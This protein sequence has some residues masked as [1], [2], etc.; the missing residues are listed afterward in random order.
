MLSQAQTNSALQKLA[1]SFLRDLR[2]AGADSTQAGWGQFVGQKDGTQVGLYGTCAGS[3]TVALAYGC[4]RIPEGA[5]AYLTELWQQRNNPG[6]DGQRYF[7]L[8]ARLAFFLMALRQSDHPSFAQFVGDVDSELRDRIL[9]D[10]LFVGWQID[11]KHRGETGDEF[12]TAIGILAFGLT[13]RARH[14]VPPEIVR[15]AECLQTR[16]E[17]SP[18][19]NVGVR[20]LYLAAVTTVLEK[21]QV[22]G[23]LRRLVR[24]NRPR[25][26]NRDQ[27]SLYFWDYWFQGT[28][29]MISRRDYFHV[30]SD[31]LD[32]LLAC[33]S[34]AGQFQKLAALDVADEDLKAV[35]DSGLYFAGRQLAASNNQA[36]ISLAL[37]KIKLLTAVD[38]KINR[39]KFRYLHGIPTNVIGCVLFPAITLVMAVIAS[40][41]P[42]RLLELLQLMTIVGATTPA[43][44]SWASVVLQVCGLIGLTAWGAPLA[45]RIMSYVRSHLS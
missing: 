6:T 38:T 30:P 10:G 41:S 26:S 25:K 27:D 13:V 44:W 4:G 16:I 39:L 33:G 12:T 19:P 20:K 18:P 42:D 1:D 34:A 7:A 5:I 24:L 29:G 2:P 11:R 32:I 35:L 17:G 9:D 28:N 21:Q 8:T 15:S 40:A 23:K 37:S 36:W 31:A 43:W 14:D 22:T 45:L 3:I